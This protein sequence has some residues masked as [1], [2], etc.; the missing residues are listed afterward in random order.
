MISIAVCNISIHHQKNYTFSLSLLLSSEPEYKSLTLLLGSF[1][2]SWS[3]SY[4]KT[5]GGYIWKTIQII[6]KKS[7]RCISCSKIGRNTAWMF[8]S[9][10]ATASNTG[11]KCNAFPFTRSESGWPVRTPAQVV[12][13]RKCT[14]V[15]ASKWAKLDWL[16]ALASLAVTQSSIFSFTWVVFVFHHTSEGFMKLWPWGSLGQ[17]LWFLK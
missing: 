2:S 14:A 15:Q 1:C 5:G 3:I 9:R 4:K 12:A 13:R 8:S 17:H 7:V 16:P 6:I 10:E 11:N